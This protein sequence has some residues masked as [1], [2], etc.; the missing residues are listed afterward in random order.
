MTHHTLQDFDQDDTTVGCDGGIGVPELVCS[1][2]FVKSQVFQLT[3]QSSSLNPVL[4]FSQWFFHTI[5][6]NLMTVVCRDKK[7]THPKETRNDLRR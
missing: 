4:T 7:A 2:G 6:D 5:N 3:H 1:E